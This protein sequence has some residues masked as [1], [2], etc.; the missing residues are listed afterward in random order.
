MG[1][2]A[3]C[4]APSGIRIGVLLLGIAF[5]CAL[6]GISAAHAFPDHSDPNVGAAVQSAPA[7]VRIWFDGV[8]EPPFSTIVVR[9]EGGK[10]VDKG[11]GQVNPNDATLLEV[12]LSPLPSG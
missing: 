6:S 9:N 5:T 2:K 11:N 7:R 10:R 1:D 8:L 3:A 12:D 4:S